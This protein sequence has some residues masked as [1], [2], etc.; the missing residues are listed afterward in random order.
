MFCRLCP[1]D[2]VAAA[3]RKVLIKNYSGNFM[4]YSELKDKRKEREAYFNIFKVRRNF[5]FYL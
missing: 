2:V 4:R 3:I 5:F 1:G